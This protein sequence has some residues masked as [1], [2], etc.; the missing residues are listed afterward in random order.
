MAR[1]RLRLRRS[2]SKL[3]QVAQLYAQFSW[4]HSQLN[5]L[6]LAENAKRSWR[7]RRK[8]TSA[9]LNELVFLPDLFAVVIDQH[10]AGLESYLGALAAGIDPNDDNANAQV[11]S[12]LVVELDAGGGI[13]FIIGLYDAGIAVLAQDRLSVGALKRFFNGIAID[14]AL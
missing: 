14:V 12:L 1:S 5:C 10:V 3:Q 4:P 2:L 11:A 6:V 13:D 9:G 7:V 8:F